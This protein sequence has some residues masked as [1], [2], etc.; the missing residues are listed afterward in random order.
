MDSQIGINGLQIDIGIKNSVR[1][2]ES[3]K[4]GSQHLMPK[5]QKMS[6]SQTK[7]SAL[8]DEKEAQA[9]QLD[10][11]K[12]M[13]QDMQNSIDVG[14]SQNAGKR[15]GRFR[16]PQAH[17][18]L[19]SSQ[20]ATTHDSSKMHVYSRATNN[21]ARDTTFNNTKDVMRLLVNPE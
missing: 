11:T 2:G 16:R 17:Q 20:D 7:G 10:I 19:L 13:V 4:V 8:I 21:F 12:W 6:T 14:T 15:L 5:T 9:R 3:L 1:N 18:L